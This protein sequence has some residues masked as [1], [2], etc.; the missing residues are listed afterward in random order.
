MRYLCSTAP[1]PLHCTAL[2]CMLI[3]A[4]TGHCPHLSVVQGLSRSTVFQVPCRR[5]GRGDRQSPSLWESPRRARRLCDA[6]SLRSSLVRGPLLSLLSRLWDPPGFRSR[7]TEHRLQ[8]GGGGSLRASQH[9]RYTRNHVSLDA[10]LCRKE[11]CAPEP[12]ISSGI[13]KLAGRTT[14]RLIYFR[15]TPEKKP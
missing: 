7:T 14:W 9:T 8:V 3:S 13:S 4:V 2:H 5:W 12:L 10:L 6:L 1:L 11:Y 15:N